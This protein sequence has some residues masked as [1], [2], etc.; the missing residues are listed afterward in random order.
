M[1]FCLLE[2]LTWHEISASLMPFVWKLTFFSFFFSLILAY[3]HANCSVL[4]R[5]LVLVKKKKRKYW[6]QKKANM[7]LPPL[8]CT[9]CQSMLSLLSTSVRIRRAIDTVGNFYTW[10]ISLQ[11]KIWNKYIKKTKDKKKNF[12]EKLFIVTGWRRVKCVTI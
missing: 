7:L 8:E 4:H 10:T 11:G 12:L 9:V 6:R 2:S 1:S 5:C 3:L